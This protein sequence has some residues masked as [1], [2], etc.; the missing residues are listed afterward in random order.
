MAGTKTDS[1]KREGGYVI[2]ESGDATGG[3]RSRDSGTLTLTAGVSGMVVAKVTASGKWKQLNTAGADGTQ[4][5]AGVLF[6]T[7][8]ASSTDKRVVVH[9]RD[10]EVNGNELTWP[11]GISGPNKTAAIA[12]LAALGIIVR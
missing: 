3:A 12:A 10:C 8:D 9:T 11:A 2:S 7:A 1:G 6:T 5:A 4:N